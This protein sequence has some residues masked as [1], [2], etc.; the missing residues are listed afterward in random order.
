MDANGNIVNPVE[1][2]I[3][4]PGLDG[5]PAQGQLMVRMGQLKWFNYDGVN[6]LKDVNKSTRRPRMY[7]LYAHVK[8]WGEDQNSKGIYLRFQ[9][10]VEDGRAD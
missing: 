3:L 9:N 8:F 5:Q 4:P 7:D 1:S 2:K 6:Y 10:T